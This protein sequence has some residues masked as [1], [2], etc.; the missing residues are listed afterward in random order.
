MLYTLKFGTITMS[1]ECED[2]ADFVRWLIEVEILTVT[3][4][5]GHPIGLAEHEASTSG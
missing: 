4:E 2:D 3:S 1:R 5:T